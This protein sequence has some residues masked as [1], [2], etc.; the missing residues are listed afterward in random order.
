MKPI[1]PHNSW[2]LPIEEFHKHRRYLP[3][4][5]APGGWYFT[6]SNTRDRRVLSAEER[7]IVFS[8]IRFLDRRKYDLLAAVVMPDHFHLILHPLEKSPGVFYSLS[9][10]F[11]SIKSFTSNKI[12]VRVWQDENYDHIIRNEQD[13]YEKLVYLLENPVAAGLVERPEE[14]PFLYLRPFDLP[15]TARAQAGSAA[16]RRF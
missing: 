14:Y 13:Y 1:T 7:D 2:I 4:W 12:G 10:I 8:A 11:H 9:E 6:D 15:I 5:Q 3:H 16:P